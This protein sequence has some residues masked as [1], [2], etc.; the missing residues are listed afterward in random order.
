MSYRRPDPFVSPR[1]TFEVRERMSAEGQVITPFDE[2]AAGRAARALAAVKP[3]AIAICFLHAYVN[4][5]H[6]DRLAE[7]CAKV[8]PDI[9]TYR[10]SQISPA[11]REY[12]RAVTTAVSAYVGPPMERYLKRLGN[13]L[14]DLGVS[15]PIHVM[16]SSGGVMTL[17]QAAQRAIRTIESGPAAGVVSTQILSGELGNSNLLSFD[18]GGTTAKCGIVRQGQAERRYEFFVGGVASW[19]GRSGGMPIRIPVIDLAEVGAGGGSIAWLDS[20]GALQVGPQ[21][22]GAEPGPACYALGG[23]HPTVSDA[24][25]LLGYFDPKKFAAG[26][27]GLSPQLASEA[28]QRFVAE[29]IGVTPLQAAAAIYEIVTA[30]MAGAVRMMTIERGL[31]PRDFVLVSFGGSG[32]VHVARIASSFDIATVVVPAHAGVRSAVGLLGTD[33]STDQVQSRL[34]VSREGAI[35]KIVSTYEILEE[36][37]ARELGLAVAPGIAASGGTGEGLRCIRMADVRY[38]GAST[39]G[40]RAGAPG[41]LDDRVLDR[42]AGAFFEQYKELYGVGEPGLTEIVNCRLRLERIVPKWSGGRRTGRREPEAVKATRI[43]SRLAWFEEAGGQ[44]TT[45]VYDWQALGPGSHLR[46]AALIDGPDS[47]VVIPPGWKAMMDV[48]GHIVLT[49]E[50]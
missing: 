45:P 46:G 29:P 43:G 19:T 37:A 42:I 44:V 8:C 3:E 5:L 7:A 22:A 4:P 25:L 36:R 14:V 34:T 38:Q 40:R 50:Q 13:A 16:E 32:P 39:S 33:L 6:E 47:T 30:S 24:N 11:M 15:A 2:R 10:S 18:M 27:V 12:G 35:E 31:D 28:I 49:R 21:S 1:L 41:P 23:I 48:L 26:T 9:P 17:E 20:A